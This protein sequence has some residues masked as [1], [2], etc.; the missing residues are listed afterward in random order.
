MLRFLCIYL[1]FVAIAGKAIW[2]KTH[3]TIAKEGSNGVFASNGV[4]N[5]PTRP[6]SWAK[7]V[8]EIE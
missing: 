2:V 3:E 1:V 5:R 4:R 7:Q 8:R 6:N